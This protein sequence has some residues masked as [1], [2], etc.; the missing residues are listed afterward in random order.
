MPRDH[1]GK[2]LRGR[3]FKPEDDL[4]GANFTRATLR[5]IHFNNLDLTDAIFIEAD[6]RGTNFTNAI[7]QG[8]DFTRAKAGVPKSWALSQVFVAIFLSIVLNFIAILINGSFLN[9]LFKSQLTQGFIINPG[10]VA[11][12]MIFIAFLMFFREGVN[13]ETL[14]KIVAAVIFF[15]LLAIALAGL[16]VIAV[17]GIVAALIPVVVFSL[18]AI[19]VAIA[20]AFT[21]VVMGEVAVVLAGIITVMA[22]IVIDANFIS[23]GALIISPAVVFLSSYMGWQACKGNEKFSLIRSFGIIF[24]SVGG[25]S[26]RGADLTSANFTD[27]MLKSTNFGPSQKKQTILANTCWLRAKQLNRAITSNSV[28]SD[29]AVR[30]LLVTG[31]GRNKSY[32]GANL[33]CAHL[34]DAHLEGANFESANLSHAMLQWARLDKANL[35]KTL[36]IGTDFTDA[37]LTG[38]CLESWNIDHTTILENVNCEFIFLL[39]KENEYGS[40]ERRPSSG[41]FRTHEFSKLFQEVLNTVDLIFRDG[42][43]WRALITAVKEV[44]VKNQ[45]TEFKVLSI[46]DKGDG[47]IVVRV[48]VS[49]DANKDILYS[50]IIQGYELALK[51]LEAKYQSELQV[52]DCEI[53]FYREKG[54]YMEKWMEKLANPHINIEFSAVAD[55]SSPEKS[56]KQVFKGPIYGGVAGNVEHDQNIYVSKPQQTLA[57]AAQEIQELLK[58]L[59][60]S[61]PTATEQQKTDF[62][63]MAVAPD[64]RKRFISALNAGW[65][66]TLKELLDNSYLNIAIAILE[67]W[68]EAKE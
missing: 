6:I 16:S 28:L 31:N 11:I 33:Y 48:E 3:Y 60:S 2:T 42:V 7:L 37:Y 35:S 56:V 24:G 1:T 13:F 32:I 45:D 30:D 61:N 34:K 4:K 52:K 58:Q 36:A 38:A 64:R 49:P 19:G 29:S 44:Q 63:T 23:P 5:G 10:H 50:Q 26:F 12:I 9:F 54:I 59:K 25:T 21:D 14:I 15:M 17:M 62:V 55:S 46:E 67:G 68:Q 22:V 57:E 39:Q 53:Y 20:I 51:A 43:D 18:S 41:T 65:K 40:R 8:V 66:E 47:V 27:A